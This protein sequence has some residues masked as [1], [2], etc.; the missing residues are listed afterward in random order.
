[1][2]VNGT[3]RPYE[4]TLYAKQGDLAIA[5]VAP[6]GMPFPIVGHTQFL[7]VGWSGDA[8]AGGE[9]S[10]DEAWALMTSRTLADARKALEMKQIQGR[11]LIGTSAGDIY[12]SLGTNPTNGYLHRDSPSPEG[13]A[14]VK[15]ALRVQ[16]TW[17]FGRLQNLA[18]DTTVYKAEEW[19]KLLAHADP[20]N[21]LARRLTNWNRKADLDSPD[22]LAFYFFK[23]ALD[24]DA[25]QLTPPDSLSKQRILAALDRTR[26][27]LETKL[28]F[29][30]KSNPTWDATWGSTWGT[31]FRVL[32]QG[33]R[34]AMPV[35]GG[36]L[37]EVGIFTPRGW[38]FRP[39]DTKDPAARRLA[40]GGPLVTRIVEMSSK[41]T[42]VAAL[43]SGKGTTKR[44]FFRD[45]KE[46]EKSSAPK[47]QLIFSNE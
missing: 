1:M 32:P 45:R 26:Q 27:L 4:M 15:E 38:T 7:S 6:V 10:F 23:L 46:L 28:E 13:D 25:M 8:H 19:Q 34:A 29:N 35:G 43:D 11:V 21:K 14:V 36:H 30:G 3:M 39:G 44:T 12:D 22:A 40:V 18:F 5:G 42:A 9:K 24:R 20:S 17:S 33:A 37:E 41:P 47:K 16:T 2:Q 31:I